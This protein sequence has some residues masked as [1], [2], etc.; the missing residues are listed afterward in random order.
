MKYAF[1]IRITIFCVIWL[2]VYFGIIIKIP[3][4]FYINSIVLPKGC[5]QMETNVIITDLDGHQIIAERLIYSDK[6]EEEIKRYI[7]ENNKFSKRIKVTGFFRSNSLDYDHDI[8]IPSEKYPYGTQ[9][10]EKYILLHY[11]TMMYDGKLY[12]IMA[13]VGF[14]V[15]LIICV[16][17][18][19]IK[20]NQ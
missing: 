7:D 9:D 11:S 16:L 8:L 1:R 20:E 18:Y 13:L 5:K 14:I 10:A 15:M 2:L 3:F 6:S 17:T 19:K 12:Q 4:Y